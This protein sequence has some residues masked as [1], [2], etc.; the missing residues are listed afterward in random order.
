MLP[1]VRSCLLSLLRVKAAEFPQTL[2][3][4]VDAISSKLKIHHALV[5]VA[6]AA[7]QVLVEVQMC[8]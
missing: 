1:S 3:P 2:V 6:D 7:K 8:I 5:A 4:W